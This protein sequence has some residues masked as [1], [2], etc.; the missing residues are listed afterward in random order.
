MRH[1]RDDDLRIDDDDDES[2]GKDRQFVTALARGLEVLRAFRPGD[3]ELGN[4]EL[5]ERTGLPKPTLVRLTHTLTKLGYL[6]QTEAHGR[7]RLGVGVLA[8]GYALLTDLQV[9]ERARPLMQAL[10]DEVDASVS[11]GSRDRLSMIYVETCRGPGHITLRLGV[12]D[13]V[14]IGRT[15]MGRAFLAALPETERAFLLD[16]LARREADDFPAILRGVEQAMRELAEKG[17][18]VAAGDWQPDVSAVGVPVILPHG[19]ISFALNCGGPAF[20]FSRRQLEEE[21][22]PKL[23]RLGRKLSTPAEPG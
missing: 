1:T 11:L 5:A 23:A 8:L 6:V 4:W 9:R 12:G 17:F 14:P 16:H 13:R 3:V 21:L 20:L 22:G 2:A 10:A 18:V 19:Q 15:A 7:Y